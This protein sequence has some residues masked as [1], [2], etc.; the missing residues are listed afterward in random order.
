MEPNTFGGGVLM[1]AV[2]NQLTLD[3]AVQAVLVAVLTSSVTAYSTV[4]VLQK[5]LGFIRETVVKNEQVAQTLAT[6]VEILA[7]RQA[8]GL[9][10]AAVIH[11]NHELRI[12]TLEKRK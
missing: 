8:A 9:A 5:E 10:E 2:K 3:N 12:Q 6:K 7:N 11:S 4:Q 1:L